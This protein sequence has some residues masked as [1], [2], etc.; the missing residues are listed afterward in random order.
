MKV[1]AKRVTLATL[2]SAQR[3]EIL[4]Q[5]RDARALLLRDSESF[6]RASIT[7]E[8]VGQVLAAR[9]GTGLGAYRHEI[10][11]HANQVWKEPNV[12]YERLFDVVK[13]ARNTAVHDGA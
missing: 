3:V 7:L 9:I 1:D 11:A 12:D 4:Q 10:V 8:Q 2:T 5:L 6:H 13:R